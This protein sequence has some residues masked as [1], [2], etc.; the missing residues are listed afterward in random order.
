MLA[1][2]TVALALT[3][4]MLPFAYVRNHASALL[5]ALLLELYRPL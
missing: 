1:A 5:G 3:A 4:S 2:G